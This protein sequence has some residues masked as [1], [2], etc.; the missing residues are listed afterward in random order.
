MY[1]FL[2]FLLNSLFYH[3]YYCC[4]TEQVA[5]EAE[6]RYSKLENKLLR[7]EEMLNAS[8]LEVQS[9]KEIIRSMELKIESLIQIEKTQ[10]ISINQLEKVVGEQQNRIQEMFSEVS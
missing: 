3:C 9:L 1:T 4:K 10:K 7:T 2:I 8:K 5:I 6:G